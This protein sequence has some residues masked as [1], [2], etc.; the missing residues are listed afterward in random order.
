MILIDTP[1][2]NL[3]AEEYSSFKDFLEETTGIV[4]GDN[5]AFLVV[6]RLKK[7]ALPGSIKNFSDLLVVAD[8]DK[9]LREKIIGAMT[10][11]ETSWYRDKK[12][13]DCLENNILPELAKSKRH[14]LKIWSVACSTGQE[15]YSVSM[16]IEDC[17]KRYPWINKHFD[18]V[19]TDI[20]KKVLEI[21]RAGRYDEIVTAR[22]LSEL[23]KRQYFNEY[24]NEKG[25]HWEI[26]NKIKNRVKFESINLKNNFSSLGKFDIIFCRNVLIYFSSDLKQDV[27]KRMTR[28]INPGG[29]LV[30]GG[31]ETMA[32]YTDSYEMH[33]LDSVVYYKL[34]A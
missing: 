31:T 32:N 18:I 21:A 2:S 10:T 23:R 34:K 8:R 15:P 5:K 13:F 1:L 6:S 26:A 25:I 22:G 27:L 3:S 16:S 33:T 14:H 20:S 30:L 7:M 29:Y 11:N 24:F 19:G 4:L 17:I 12:I 28:Q 9:V